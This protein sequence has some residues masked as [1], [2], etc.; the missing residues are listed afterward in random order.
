[1]KVLLIGASG[2]LGR[3]TKAALL[4]AGH[5][6]ISVGRSS[7]DINADVYDVESIKNMYKAAGKVDVVINMGGEQPWNKLE[8]TTDK[9]VEVVRDALV[10]TIQLVRYGVDYVND[11][12][13]FILTSGDIDVNPLP[14]FSITAGMIPFVDTLARSSS[15]SMPRGIRINSIRVPLL[16]ESAALFDIKGDFVTTAECAEWYMEAI[17]DGMTG[18]NRGVEG[19]TN[20]VPGN[21]EW[22]MEEKPDDVYEKADALKDK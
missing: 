10:G 22:D 4:K 11:N 9:D 1:M 21:Y 2:M 20:F 5:E 3:P 7:G 15:R 6:V 12:G 13:L 19:W 18:Q 8:D 16:A 14:I 17:T